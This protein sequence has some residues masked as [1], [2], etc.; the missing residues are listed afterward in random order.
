MK[1]LLVILTWIFFISCK[2][3]IVQ[4]DYGFSKGYFARA[5]W[6]QIDSFH[7]FNERRG[8]HY[9]SKEGYFM[10]RDSVSTNYFKEVKR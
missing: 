2:D 7:L 8:L 5:D 3:R 1:L 9:Y 6:K 10:K 4:T